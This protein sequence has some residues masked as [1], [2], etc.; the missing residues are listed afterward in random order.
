TIK[1]SV[2]NSQNCQ[3]SQTNAPKTNPRQIS[4]PKIALIN[5]YFSASANLRFKWQPL[6]LV[7]SRRSKITRTN[8]FE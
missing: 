3:S 8:L 2:Y 1:S 4:F 6:P 7:N 5:L